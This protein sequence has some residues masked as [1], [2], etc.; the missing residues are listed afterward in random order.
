MQAANLLC[1]L[2]HRIELK[3]GIAWLKH[4]VEKK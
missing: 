2:A 3:K 1:F 4:L